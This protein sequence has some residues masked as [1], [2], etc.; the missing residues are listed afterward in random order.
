MRVLHVLHSSWPRRVGYSLR[1]EAIVAHQRRRGIEV[2]AV[3]MPQR[4]GGDPPVEVFAGVA[5]HRVPAPRRALPPG[6]REAR[7][8]AALYARLRAVAAAV[9]PDVVHAHSP[10]LVGAPA[11]CVAAERRVPLVYEVRDLWENASV[12]RGKFAADSL[13]YRAARALETAVLRRAAAAVTICEGLRRELAPRVG[14]PRRLFVVPN[15]VEPEAFTPRP[16]SDADV[17]RFGLAGK[18]VVGYLGTFQPYEGLDVLIRAMPALRAI[19]P[20]AHLLITGGGGVEA[21]LRALVQELGLAAHVTFTGPVPHEQVP[22]LL[23][24]AELCVYPRRS[25]R[26]TRTTTPLKPL[27]A[28]AMGKA[29]IVSDVPA[30]AELVDDGVTGFVARA[31]DPEHLA[32]TI[33]GVLAAPGRAREVGAAARAAVTAER[34]WSRLVARYDEVYASAL[35]AHR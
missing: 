6:L 13:P 7:A 23:A 25:T 5:Y 16:R 28:M 8:M 27:E 15:G 14:D 31:G 20:A 2:A 18:E 17:A 24:L 11:L 3:T 4:D 26:T 19:R 21:E 10:V 1:T 12:D 22:A 30:M 32:R 35:E 33:A 34:A 29:V 9:R